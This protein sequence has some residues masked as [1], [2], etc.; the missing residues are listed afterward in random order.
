MRLLTIGVHSIHRDE[1]MA[2]GLKARGV[3]EVLQV[4][5]GFISDP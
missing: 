5:L 3:L 1:E 2:Q 4:V